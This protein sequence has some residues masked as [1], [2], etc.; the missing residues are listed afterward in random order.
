MMDIKTIK[1]KSKN[2][3]KD[4]LT[5]DN[6]NY[7]IE[8]RFKDGFKL[9]DFSEPGAMLKSIIIIEDDK[10]LKKSYKNVFGVEFPLKE[11]VEESQYAKDKSLDLGFI[12]N[13]VFL[14]CAYAYARTFKLNKT[15]HGFFADPD[16]WKGKVEDLEYG[17]DVDEHVFN[18]EGG[19]KPYKGSKVRTGPSEEKST[20]RRKKEADEIDLEIENCKGNYD[21][22]VEVAKSYGITKDVCARYK[23]FADDGKPGL[24]AM[25]IKNR[26]REK[27]RRDAK[28]G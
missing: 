11:A 2:L 27:Q 26:I 13:G 9:E 10:I 8:K 28:N 25:N 22:L 3:P 12:K 24:L 19:V 1:K 20:R 16:Y 23:H 14:A 5:R 4:G 7:A 21:K 17:V 15:D 18:E 6:I